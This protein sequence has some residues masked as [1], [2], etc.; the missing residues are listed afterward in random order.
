MSTGFIVIN[1]PRPRIQ[2]QLR[3]GGGV[4]GT[5]T[6]SLF[7]LL[8]VILQIFGPDSENINKI[9]FESGKRGD[10]MDYGQMLTESYEY[11]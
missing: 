3:D 5:R 7:F 6:L 2:S 4:L 1:G 11:T 9:M 10:P 8:I